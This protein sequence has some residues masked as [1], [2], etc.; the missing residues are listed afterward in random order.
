MRNN[1]KY[2][3]A[4]HNFAAVDD[5]GKTAGHDKAEMDSENKP[6][7][8]VS[9]PCLITK[10]PYR[11]ANIKHAYSWSQWSSYEKMPVTS[12]STAK[13]H[14]TRT[15]AE[16]MPANNTTLQE[17]PPKSPTSIPA[18]LYHHPDA[19]ANQPPYLSG[20]VISPHQ[21]MQAYYVPHFEMG[22]DTPE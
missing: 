20:S 8:A 17:G 21:E 7:G 11:R 19:S 12:T 9:Y 3:R 18:E 6:V 16:E 15:G 5:S 14:A 22:A 4:S 13:Q 2:S 10:A 1:R